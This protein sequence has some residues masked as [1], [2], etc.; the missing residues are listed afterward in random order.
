MTWKQAAILA[1]LL[2]ST[3]LTGWLL[4]RQDSRPG[5]SHT[6]M[7][8]PEYFIDKL[9]LRVTTEEGNVRYRIQAENM[10]QYPDE[11]GFELEEPAMQIIHADS[12]EWHIQSQRGHISTD[13][14]KILLLGEVEIRRLKDHT[15]PDLS[16]LT[17]NI[18]VKPSQETAETD[19]RA[20]IL[21]SRYRVEAVG[22]RV[23]FRQ[24][25][26]ELRSQV[27]SRFDVAG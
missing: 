24:S 8:S 13:G 25:Q 19:N 26:L 7:R 1:L 14:Q 10:S 4:Q 6:S 17:S 27:R 21:A 15:A 3:G 11:E 9:H 18:L 2:F 20:T 12:T 16:I 5:P 22:L 23:N